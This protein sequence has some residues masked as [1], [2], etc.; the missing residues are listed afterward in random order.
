MCLNFKLSF[1]ILTLHIYI[2]GYHYH[3][4]NHHSINHHFTVER[5][6]LFFPRHLVVSCQDIPDRW[7]K[8]NVENPPCAIGKGRRSARYDWWTRG[9]LH[10]FVPSCYDLTIAMLQTTSR[11]SLFLDLRWHCMNAYVVIPKDSI[12]PSNS[13][14]MIGASFITSE[15]FVF[16]FHETILRFSE[17]MGHRFC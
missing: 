5:S 11:G 6:L 15:T 12:Q 13:R 8:L 7:K 2:Y 17:P 9:V 10:L 4:I 16:R 14:M 1:D 3:E